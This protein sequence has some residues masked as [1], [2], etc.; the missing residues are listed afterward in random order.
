M[1]FF[2]ARQGGEDLLTRDWRLSFQER[3]TVAEQELR[4]STWQ[5]RRIE[6][7]KRLATWHCQC[8]LRLLLLVFGLRSYDALQLGASLAGPRHLP[9]DVGH[10]HCNG[11]S[12]ELFR[13]D[14]FRNRGRQV[15]FTR[16]LKL[17]LCKLGRLC[18][19]PGH[20]R[21]P[22]LEE[23]KWLRARL[24]INTDDGF[25]LVQRLVRQVGMFTNRTGAM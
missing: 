16:L 18:I 1:Q 6:N 22:L 12:H 19:E 4:V 2:A 9:G 13:C 8:L 11:R 14:S 3:H 7:R 15:L 17:S 10:V 20:A 25:L 21:I 24:F 5:G 23:S